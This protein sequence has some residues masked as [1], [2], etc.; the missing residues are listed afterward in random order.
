MS[1]FGSSPP[2]LVT[3]ILRV[4]SWWG[5]RLKFKQ[6][7]ELNQFVTWPILDGLNTKHAANFIPTSL[8]ASCSSIIVGDGSELRPPTLLSLKKRGPPLLFQ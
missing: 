2:K 4:S 5:A 7:D 3:S 8:S 6:S 1:A